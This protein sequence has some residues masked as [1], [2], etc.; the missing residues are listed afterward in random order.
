MVLKLGKD[1]LVFCKIMNGDKDFRTYAFEV[2][3]A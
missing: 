3:L 1:Y 2:F